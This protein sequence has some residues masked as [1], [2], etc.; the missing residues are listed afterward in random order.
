MKRRCLILIPAGGTGIVTLKK[1]DTS[2]VLLLAILKRN[3]TSLVLILGSI[4]I[5]G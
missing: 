4:L 1:I 5:L 2:L 3:Y